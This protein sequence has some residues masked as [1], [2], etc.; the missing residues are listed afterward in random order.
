MF[1]R[2][3]SRPLLQSLKDS[4]VVLLHGA[5]QTGKSTL[6]QWVAAGP[7]P[8]RYLTLDDVVVLSAARTDPAGFVADLEGPVV[9]DEVQR[10]PDLLLAIKERVD[11]DRRP[12]RFL[13]TGSANILLA[14]QLSEYLTGRMEI[15]TLWPLSQGEI[16]GV[17]EGFVD[18]LFRERLA[19]LDAAP[20]GASDVIKRVVRGG[21]PEA[22]RRLTTVRRRAWFGGY[23]TTILQR[24]VRDLAQIERLEEMPRLLGLLAA[25]T[26]SLLNFS[27]LSRTSGLPQTTLKRYLS[28]LETA[29]LVQLLPAWAANLSKRLVKS[30]KVMLSDTGLVAHLLGLDA[31][32]LAADK[33]LLGHLLE[34]FVA[35]ELLKQTAWSR[36]QPR[37]FHFRTETGQEVDIVLEDAGG[38]IVG[39]EVKAGATIGGEDFKGLR[40]L[41]D[42][43]GSRFRRGVALY[44][45][46][47]TVAFG[48]NLHAVPL[49]NL[50]RLGATQ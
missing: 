42:A 15:L 27:E 20:D 23:I 38:R 45:G 50:W 47:T 19:S 36:L 11:R 14:P 33:A 31:R 21:Y 16:E 40:A 49:S 29:F 24:E 7:R 12:G 1:R 18:T 43:T 26:G 4:P 10:A 2:N 48:S 25:R 35:M 44:M 37:L 13:L 22:I 46:R 9:V 5:R 3:I 32:R 6:A 17:Q 28:L 34:N 39:L 8:A 30:P 41:A